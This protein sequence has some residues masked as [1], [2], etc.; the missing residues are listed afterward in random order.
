MML[1]PYTPG[2]KLAKRLRRTMERRM[3]GVRGGMKVVSQVGQSV[4]SMLQRADP[5]KQQ[6]CGRKD[7]IVCEGGTGDCTKESV[8]YRCFCNECNEA[9]VYEG[10]TSANGYHRGK[11]HM[12]LYNSK[13]KQSRNKSFMWK[14]VSEAHE[15]RRVKFRMDVLQQYIEDAMGRQ[16]NEGVWV[17]HT[18]ED[19]LLNSGGEWR[20]AHVPRLNPTH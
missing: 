8:R 19:R 16:I 11:L 4:C 3:G 15:G 14:H 13:N 2:D 6:K 10:E 18:D 20:L 1:V 17:G 9:K 7:C 5:W 12:E